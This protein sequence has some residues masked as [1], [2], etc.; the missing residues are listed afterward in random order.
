MSIIAINAECWIG[1]TDILVTAPKT[2]NAYHLQIFAATIGTSA[3]V[4]VSM[5]NRQAQLPVS[6]SFD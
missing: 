3:S 4:L 2:Q 5:A 6:Y 1:L